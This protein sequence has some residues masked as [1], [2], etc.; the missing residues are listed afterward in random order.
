MIS[1]I[2]FIR[3][4]G[5]M[6]KWIRELVKNRRNASI[7]KHDCAT[8]KKPKGPNNSRV[9]TPRR[10]PKGD[11]RTKTQSL[12][13]ETREPK[14]LTP[15]ARSVSQ[16]PSRV[17]IAKPHG[18]HSI[19]GQPRKGATQLFSRVTLQWADECLPNKAP[20]PGI[21]RVLGRPQKTWAAEDAKRLLPRGIPREAPRTSTG[22]R[23]Y[24][25]I[26]LGPPDQYSTYYQPAPLRKCMM[27]I[28]P[29]LI[30][31]IYRLHLFRLQFYRNLRL[32]VIREEAATAPYWENTML[33][34]V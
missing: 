27:F 31:H 20:S 6:I 9:E 24:V 17:N 23:E 32:P 34:H 13:R 1:Y 8:V 25:A 22:Q 18:Q 10:T 4:V 33:T 12:I 2:W 15:P 30:A 29:R 26:E 19:R 14:T 7:N 28:T 21:P 5:L 16:E 11:Q 3:L